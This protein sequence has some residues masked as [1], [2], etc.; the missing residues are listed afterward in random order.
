MSRTNLKQQLMK[1]QLIQQELREKQCSSH[2]Q[3]ARL[4]QSLQAM[5]QSV[6]QPHTGAL[7]PQHSGAQ[8]LMFPSMM[9]SHQLFQKV[10]QNH[11]MRPSLENPTNYH[12]LQT[13]QKISPQQLSP[14]SPLHQSHHPFHSQSVPNVPTQLSPNCLPPHHT[15]HTNTD[16]S[17]HT[18]TGHSLSSSALG[19]TGAPQSPFPLSPDSPLSAPPSSACSTSEL[20][21]V[22]DVL[23]G[24]DNRADVSQMDEELVGAIAATLPADINYFLDNQPMTPTGDMSSSSCPQLT[25]QEMKAWQKDRQKKDN[26][27]QIERRRRYNINDRI[28]ELGTLLPKNEDTKHFDLV[29]DMK[30]NK[31]TILKASVDYVRLLKRENMRLATE[32]RRYKEMENNYRSLQMQFQELQVRVGSSPQPP[33]QQQQQQQQQTSNWPQMMNSNRKPVNGDNGLN[34]GLNNGND[35]SKSDPFLSAP[36][37]LPLTDADTMAAA[38]SLQR[39]IK[40]EFAAPLS[41]VSPSQ[42]SSGL[43][44][45]LPSGASPA[46]HYFQFN[47]LRHDPILSAASL[48]IKNEAYSPQSMDI[49]H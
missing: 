1:Q 12:V 33:H 15:N 42:S 18:N 5:S 38:Q 9:N 7:Q 4:S 3:S 25:E 11:Q 41:P 26:H 19:S 49:C 45:S 39:I 47:E 22:F 32:E 48:S 6:P 17:H 23:G 14:H 10:Q 37:S 28:K 27:N 20:D 16:H 21:D 44:S 43:G 31:G 40:Q 13:Q 8:S 35:L 29:K 34:N 36:A 24:F 30:Q 2:D 46:Q